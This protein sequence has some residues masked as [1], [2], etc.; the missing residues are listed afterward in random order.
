MHIRLLSKAL[1]GAVFLLLTTAAQQTSCRRKAGSEAMIPA[2]T[3]RSSKFLV[4]KLQQKDL[5][6]V[7]SLTAHAKISAES[8]GMTVQA[9]ANLIWIRDSALWVNVK[10]LG[11]EAMRALVTRDSVI[12]LNRLESTYSAKELS[13]LERQYSLPEGFPL[14]Q[15]LV[16]ASAWLAP[17]LLFQ[18]DI[19]DSLH[20]LSGSNNRFTVDYRIEEGSYRLRQ[21]TFVQQ[22]DARILTLGFD[23]F[24][25]IP[26]TGSFPYLRRIEA[27]S[28]E[29]GKITLE[30]EFT[31]VEINTPPTYKFDIPAH[32]RRTE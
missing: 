12:V 3:V 17:D 31:D 16:L 14:L 19:K 8:D 20:R 4:Q 18:S 23:D 1:F 25:K 13:T 32:Y 27:F 28:P 29:S 26:G 6:Q 30:I 9:N 24:K 7:H 21:E 22:R 10:K 5:E 2:T 15:N 11:I